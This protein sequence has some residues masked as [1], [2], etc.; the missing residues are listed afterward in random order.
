MEVRAVDAQAVDGDEHVEEVWPLSRLADLLE[1][2]D[3]VIVAA[4]LTPESH[5]MIDAAMLSRMRPD[6]YLIVVSRGGIVEEHAL[7]AALGEG[8]LAGAAIDVAEQEPLPPDSPSGTRRTSSS[9]P[10]SLAPRP[11]R[12]AAASRS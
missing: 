4:P 10:T 9:R 5:H 11:R 1:L 6:A 2:T 7:A 3:V 8:R 12:S